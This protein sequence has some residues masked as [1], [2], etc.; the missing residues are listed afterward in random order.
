MSDEKRKSIIAAETKRIAEGI[1]ALAELAAGNNSVE[2][3]RI[4]LCVRL[5]DDSKLI[6][7]ARQAKLQGLA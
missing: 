5:M 1:A 6:V 3:A 2:L 4:M 7:A